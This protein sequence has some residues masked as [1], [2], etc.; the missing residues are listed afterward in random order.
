MALWNTVR[1][2]FFSAVLFALPYCQA[3]KPRIFNGFNDLFHGHRYAA[4][5]RNGRYPKQCGHRYDYTSFTQDQG[6]RADA[7]VEMFRFAWNGYYQYAFPHDSLLAKN[8]SYYDDRNGWGLTAID[9]L[10]TAIIMGQQDIVDVILDFVP[11]IDFTKNNAKK[12]GAVTTSLF[13]T[14]IRYMG[15]LL[16]SYDLLKGPFNYTVT[17]DKKVDAL[18]DQ[19]RKLADALKFCFD[20]PSGLPVNFV[21]IDNQTFADSAIMANGV[22]TASLAE[23]GT[24]VLEWQHLSDLTGDPSYGDLA[25]K[26][27]SYWFKAP[28]VWPGLTGS[29]FR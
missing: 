3:A 29:N 5:C 16:S 15:G 9:G 18:L 1:A 12:P 8:N 25:Q 7:V 21:Y 20:T 17:D 4:G 22:R 14:N 27:E 19:A 13:E 23:I 6:A 28:E 2:A 26:A 10:D 11:K 24:L